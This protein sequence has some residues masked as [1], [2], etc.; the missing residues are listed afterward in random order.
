MFLLGLNEDEIDW[1]NPNY[2]LLK[3]HLYRVQKFTSGDYYFR[4][5][6]TATIQNKEEKQQINSFGMGKNGW[7]THNPI[8]V[9]VS[10][11]GKIEKL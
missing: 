5:C 3:E 11:S 9:K 8:K 7:T 6:N 10:V 2:G 1:E 4:I